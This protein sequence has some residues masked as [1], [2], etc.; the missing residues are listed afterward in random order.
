M[1][2]WGRSPAGQD[3]AAVPRKPLAMRSVLCALVAYVIEVAAAIVMM[4]LPESLP[5]PWPTLA[6]LGL[7]VLFGVVGPLIHIVGIVL[8]VK[9]VSRADE[10]KGV[11]ILGLILNIL[12]IGGVILGVFAAIGFSV[13]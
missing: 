3:L 5:L 10:R 8:G 11:A 12:A 9:A 7:A 1:S 4:L 13:A 6:P 2:Q